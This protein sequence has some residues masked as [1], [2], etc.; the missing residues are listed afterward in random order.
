MVVMEAVEHRWYWSAPSTVATVW[1]NVSVTDASGPFDDS[2]TFRLTTNQN[3]NYSI[4]T[5]PR[6]TYAYA[7]TSTNVGFMTMADSVLG[8]ME[9]TLTFT[10]DLAGTILI[11]RDAGGFQAGTFSLDRP[12]GHAFL[13]GGL[14]SV[15]DTTQHDEIFLTAEAGVLSVKRNNF[16]QTFNLA[17]VTSIS[18]EASEGNDLISVGEGV[19]GL[20]AI[21]GLGKDTLIGGNGSDT[22][23]G[24]GGNDIVIG[25]A[26]DDRLNGIG[27]H[28]ALQGGLGNDRLYGG[29]GNDSLAG[30][31]NVDRLFG[32]DG[33]DQ[34]SGGT[35]NDKLY[36]EAGADAL[37]GGTGS[38]LASND[39]LDTLTSVE[40]IL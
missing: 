11:E 28:D 14:L 37:S 13:G 1:I 35:G 32:G 4:N 36:G 40:T 2:G 20:Y 26:G 5:V 12:V 16:T 6:G 8:E 22:L 25:G 10:E 24:A 29:L 38:D 33:D 30:Q 3:G 27:G 31:S 19:P 21:G 17:S 34:L 15:E 39:P 7:R 9:A 18:I 23:T